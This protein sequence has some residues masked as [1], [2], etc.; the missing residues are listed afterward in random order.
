MSGRH[1]PEER[2]RF[3]EGLAAPESVA[4]E[5]HAAEQGSRDLLKAIHRYV[6]QHQPEA[7]L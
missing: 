4:H 5:R 2:S 7:V 1:K 3:A 6:A